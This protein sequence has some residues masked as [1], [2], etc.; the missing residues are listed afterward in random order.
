MNRDGV[1]FFHSKANEN[2]KSVN[3]CMVAG[4][5]SALNQM[6]SESADQELEA[7]TFKD[8][9]LIMWP[10]SDPIPFYCIARAP[11]KEKEK[12][13]RKSLKKI[14]KT[15]SKL[16]FGEITHWSGNVDI[17]IDFEDIIK[18]YWD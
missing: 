13:I 10:Y 4:F 2:V 9:Q 15:F 14:A 12:N 8:S 18:D 1:P 16:F 7:I 6:V 3:D 11:L 17:F 5:I